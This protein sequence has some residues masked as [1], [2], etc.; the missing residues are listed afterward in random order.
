MRNQIKKIFISSKSVIYGRIFAALKRINEELNKMNYGKQRNE[1][2]I[3]TVTR[4]KPEWESG[5]KN[6]RE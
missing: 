6:P 1:R 2:H 5:K 3:Q 4:K